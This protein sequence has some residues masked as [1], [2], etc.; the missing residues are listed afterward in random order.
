[1]TEIELITAVITHPAGY[2]VDL[3]ATFCVR[4][5]ED[6]SYCVS[7]EG[8]NL[9]DSWE[10]CFTDPVEAAKYFVAKRHELQLG[11]DIELELMK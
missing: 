9:K 2:D 3:F 10:K 8:V 6:G 5:V 11:I 1:M 7:Y 4:P